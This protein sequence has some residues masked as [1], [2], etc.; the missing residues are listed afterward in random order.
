MSI[1]RMKDTGT[2]LEQADLDNLERIL[3]EDLPL[4]YKRFL[5]KSNGGTPDPPYFR[6][7]VLA[8]F[9]SVNATDETYDL[10][11]NYRFLR[12]TLPEELVPIA[13]DGLGDVVCLAVKGENRGKVYFWD[14]EGGTPRVDIRAKY[15]EIGWK[16][17]EDGEP[18]PPVKDD[19]P[20]HPDLTLIADS[21]DE[22]LDSFHD[23]DED[24]RT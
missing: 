21:F 7:S 23:L 19:W 4:A 2:L 8:E 15:P 1:R 17:Y 22:F 12:E 18:R 6:T 11:E 9:F 16:P 24:P 3:N 20:G 14:H 5:L 10:V 13:R